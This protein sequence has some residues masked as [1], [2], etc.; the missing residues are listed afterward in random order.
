MAH[1][2][3]PQ[4]NEGR[5]IP[6]IVFIPIIVCFVSILFLLDYRQRRNAQQP[7]FHEQDDE[8]TAAL[9]ELMRL[10]QQHPVAEQPSDD[11][12]NDVA[13][14]SST[15]VRRRVKK[16][17][18]KRGEKLRRK[19]E[20]RRYREYMDHQR[21]V[22]RQQAQFFEEQERIRKVEQ[23]RQRTHELNKLRKQREKQAK[24]EAKEA[25]KRQK[26][27]EKEEKKK[28]YNYNKYSE[29]LK[30]LVKENKLC[31]LNDLAKTMKLSAKDIADI[32]KQLCDQDSDFS[33]SLWSADDQQFLFVTEED[34]VHFEKELLQKKG[35]RISIHEADV[36][37][38]HHSS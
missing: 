3:P 31:S 9:E 12:Q 7:V 10:R 38:L 16:V 21:E 34:Y 20:M 28:Q 17:G 5:G 32:L 14:G 30:K 25:A 13:E 24:A 1:T 11:E 23:T 35:G 27:E 33:L 8:Q 22:Q 37:M 4:Q 6:L 2:N 26:L 15:G 18:K 29:R 19:E 36:S